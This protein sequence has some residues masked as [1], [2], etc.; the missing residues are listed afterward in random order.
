M[1]NHPLLLH[2]LEE[3]ALPITE[4]VGVELVDI[5]FSTEG[6]RRVIRFIIDH[7]DGVEVSHCEKVSRRLS[8][9]LDE[10]ENMI[11]GTYSLEVSSPGLDRPFK[12][13]RDYQRNLGKRVKVVTRTPIDGQNVYVGLLDK[14][15][16]ESP[17]GGYLL[18]EET[19]GE[20]HRHIQ[21]EEIAVCHLDVDWDAMFG[22][23]NHHPKKKKKKPTK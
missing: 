22:G 20:P 7:P 11:P 12:K 3:M 6:R 23:T 14:F 9:F 5:E 8:E 18:L 15:E 17:E 21:L 2:K 10:Q 4:E 19:E 16:P 1:L 13:E